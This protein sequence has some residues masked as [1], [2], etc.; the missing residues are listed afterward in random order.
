[1]Q[2]HSEVSLALAELKN[3]HDQFT[4]SLQ[5]ELTGVAPRIEEK[6]KRLPLITLL[7]LTR[8]IVTMNGG[9]I[10]TCEWRRD[11]DGNYETSCD[12]MF[13]FTEGGV[14]ENGARF[15]QYCGRPIIPLL[16][17]GEPE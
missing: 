7:M 16:T 6:D 3:K 4:C 11:E 5:G 14:V 10:P 1:M 8:K 2:D 15:C 12:E 13:T 9:R 17:Y